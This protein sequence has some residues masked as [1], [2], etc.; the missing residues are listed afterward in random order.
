MSRVFVAGWGAVS[1]AGWGAPALAEA[2]ARGAPLPVLS[3]T[4]PGWLKPLPERPVPPPPTRLPFLA[5]PRLRR[6]SPITHFAVAAALEATAGWR[7]RP[8]VESRLG[9]IVCLHSGC[10]QYPCRFFEETLE[11][12]A[13]ASPL[14]FP[15]TVF[16]APASHIAAVLGHTAIVNTLVGDP[17]SFL[18]GMAL[19]AAWLGE[20]R[21]AA[22]LV[23]GAEETNWIRAD[24]LRHFDRHAIATAGAGALCLSAD[25]GRS[26]GV[27]LTA[28]TDAHT[29][30]RG[31]TR[32]K[33]ARAMRRQLGEHSAGELLCDGLGDNPR[34]DAAESAAWEDSAREP[35]QPQAHP[36]RGQHGGGG[37]AVRRGLRRGGRRAF[38]RGQGQPRGL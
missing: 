10:V 37:L 24:A 34:A 16:A 26:R 32:T 9:L 36:G 17:A 2:L 21:V 5:H 38:L 33:A 23:V 20:N 29:Y 7:A 31:W 14:L 22:C 25:P 12:P 28:I 3:L 8:E 19:A 13:T 4:R 15:E 18:Q 1:P 30:T 11:D 6:T 27:E 35:A